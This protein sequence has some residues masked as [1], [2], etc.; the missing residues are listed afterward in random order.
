MV[1]QYSN[2]YYITTQQQEDLVGS[3]AKTLSSKDTLKM[4][5]SQETHTQCWQL[6]DNVYVGM[7]ETKNL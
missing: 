5:E 4:V 6:T 2:S 1:E 7:K 3:V